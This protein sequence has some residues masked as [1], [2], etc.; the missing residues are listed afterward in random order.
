MYKKIST[1]FAKTKR[2]LFILSVREVKRKYSSTTLGY[3]WIFIQPLIQM[4]IF[5]ILFSFILKL[6]I[7]NYWFI[8]LSGLIPWSFFSGALTNATD[9]IVINRDLIKKISFERLLVPISSVGSHLPVFLSSICILLFFS[10]FLG[11]PHPFILIVSISI[12]L[13]LTLG[14]SFITSSMEVYFRDISFI[15]QIIL[16]IWFY[17]TPIIYPAS[18]IPHEWKMLYLLNPLTGIISAIKYSLLGTGGFTISY[19]L[20]PAICSI[21]IFLFGF[22]LFKSRSKLFADWL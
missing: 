20:Y 15:L 10:F 17:I 7:K 2:L 22:K 4:I 5:T 13:I 19:L 6:E 1:E 21:S 9:S 18:L 16:M 12:L 3:A 11:N 8:V 14:L